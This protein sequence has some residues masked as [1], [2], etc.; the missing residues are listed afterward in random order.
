LFHYFT[1][2]TSVCVDGQSH[3]TGLTVY[4]FKIARSAH[5]HKNFQA[6]PARDVIDAGRV[7]RAVEVDAQTSLET[8]EP[9]TPPD[10][11][12]PEKPE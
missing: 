12:I 7:K 9:M 2:N 1:I 10:E 5:R 11:F 6:R 3:N 4:G 8:G